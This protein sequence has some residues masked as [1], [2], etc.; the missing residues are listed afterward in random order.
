ML[1]YIRE[2]E[3][4][5]IMQDV[6]IPESLINKLDEERQL[7]LMEIRRQKRFKMIKMIRY[8]TQFDIFQF[9]D[10]N[11]FQ[12]LFSLKQIPS[13]QY[14]TSSKQLSIILRL[15]KEYKVSPTRIFL[16]S[17]VGLEALQGYRVGPMVYL[18]DD[19][20]NVNIR[21]EG[22]YCHIQTLAERQQLSENSLIY[23]EDFDAQHQ[24]IIASEEAILSEIRFI[25]SSSTEFSCP[26]D[27]FSC[28]QQQQQLDESSNADISLDQLIACSG[29][30]CNNDIIFEYIDDRE[31]RV[32]FREQ[33]DDLEQTYRMLWMA[34]L[35]RERY[36]YNRVTSGS[37]HIPHS[38]RL[39]HKEL[40]NQQFKSSQKVLGI[41]R[42]FDLHIL[43]LEPKNPFDN[44]IVFDNS[45]SSDGMG[46]YCTST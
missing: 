6:I 21:D 35:Q 3:A 5:D 31:K 20:V 38:L 24:E 30:F 9:Q 23:C 1:I 45:L 7:Q 32:E 36:E 37:V 42:L 22:Y 25:L 4:K 17:V 27:K 12:D 39:Q 14:F 10:Y 16:H 43:F 29:L 26:I 34:Y 2:D 46:M 11:T 41:F 33:F 13:L 44:D 40:Q 8:F 28:Q 18:F 19:F 15:S